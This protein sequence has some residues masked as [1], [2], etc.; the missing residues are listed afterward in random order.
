[1]AVSNEGD[2]SVNVAG[3]KWV[4][5]PGSLEK[6]G[7][8]TETPELDTV[9][10]PKGKYWDLTGPQVN[11]LEKDGKITWGSAAGYIPKIGDVVRLRLY[12]GGEVVG[13]IRHIGNISG[14]PKSYKDDTI[15]SE[16]ERTWNGKIEAGSTSDTE[17]GLSYGTLSGLGGVAVKIEGI[18]G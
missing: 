3:N 10:F 13:V 9:V 1:M 8:K 16:W 5:N 17:N 11:Q 2:V 14:G 12:S 18:D 6:V 15:W 4:Y 7:G